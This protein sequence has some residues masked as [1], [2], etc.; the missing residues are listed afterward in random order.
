VVDGPSRL[1]GTVRGIGPDGAL[2]LEAE[3]QIVRVLAGDVSIE[4]AYD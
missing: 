3:G 4:G 1:G 2:L